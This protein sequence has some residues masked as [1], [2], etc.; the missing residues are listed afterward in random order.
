MREPLGQPRRAMVAVVVAVCAVLPLEAA[1]PGPET[2]AAWRD[3]VGRVDAA[4]DQGGAPALTEGARRT[5][6][7]GAVLAEPAMAP[8]GP[9]PDVPGGTIQ[10]WRGAV[11]LRGVTLEVLLD[12]LQR[13]PP[14]QPDIL[15]S[16]IIERDGPRQRLYLRLARRAIVSATYDTEHEVSYRRRS[17]GTAASRSVMTRVREVDDAGTPGE[18]VRA[19]GEDRGLLWRLNVYSGY[20]AVPGGVLVVIES[21]TLSRAVPALLRPVAWPIIRHVARESVERSLDALRARFA[22]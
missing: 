7:A 17:A 1:G 21:I 12:R 9:R 22:R 3:Y 5:V 16:R 4:F 13:E 20:E 10:H 8:S 19:D 14:V 2:L 15:A 6:L 18:T 11:L